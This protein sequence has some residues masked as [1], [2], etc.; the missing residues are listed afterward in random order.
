MSTTNISNFRKNLFDLTEQVINFNEPLTVTTK[1]GNIVIM[2]EEE[3][4]GIVETIY[5]S[6]VPGMEKEL[7]R[8]KNTPADSEEFVSEDEVDWN[9]L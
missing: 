9:D 1:S 7:I 3:Y 5:L 6:S 4:R 8:L 2:S